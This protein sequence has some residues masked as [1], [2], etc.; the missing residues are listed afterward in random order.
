MLEQSL[1]ISLRPKSLD[2]MIGIKNITDQIRSQLA[3]GRLP[4]AWLFDGPPGTGKTT[5]ARILAVALQCKDSKPGDYCQDCYRKYENQEFSISEINVSDD[6][7]VE[8]ARSLVDQATLLPMDG[9]YRVFILDEA[10]KLTTPAQN[11]L[12]KPLEAEGHNA[13]WFICTTDASKIIKALR[14]R[15]ISYTLPGMSEESSVMELIQT[16]LVRLK[17]SGG[18]VSEIS[19]DIIDILVKALVI[20]NISSP[21]SITMA[22]EKVLSG[23]TP[24]EAAQIDE[25]AS[26]DTYTMCKHILVGDWD[27]AKQILAKSSVEDGR[28]IRS[29]VAGRFRTTLL[30]SSGQR[31]MICANAIHELC[32]YSSFE[33]G[34][35]MSA[36]AASIYKICCMIKPPK[37]VKK[38]STQVVDTEDPNSSY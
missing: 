21:R 11:I 3:G 31:A 6:N 14:S 9:T 34:L 17:A 18:S 4:T 1:T 32:N 25:L 19:N 8:L 2:E 15:C 23:A 35:T 38:V 16:N 28:R 37:N 20:N 22:L 24:Q 7:G 5:L 30:T 27:S 36:T 13:I 12:L 33:D 10:Q 26:V 29:I